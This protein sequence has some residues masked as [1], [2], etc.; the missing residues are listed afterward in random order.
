MLHVYVEVEQ[1][2]ELK[3]WRKV[4]QASVVLQ[5]DYQP[6]EKSSVKSHWR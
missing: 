4:I 1:I 3:K 6:L 5:E 2:L